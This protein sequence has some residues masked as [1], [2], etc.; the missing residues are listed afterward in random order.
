MGLEWML[1]A[2]HRCLHCKGG[3]MTLGGTDLAMF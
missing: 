2:F 1:I 3:I